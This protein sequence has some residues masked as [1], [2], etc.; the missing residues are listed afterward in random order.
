MDTFTDVQFMTAKE[1]TQVLKAWTRFLKSGLKPEAFTKALYHHLTLHC[2][3]IAHYDRGGFYSVYFTSGDATVRF[4]RQFDLSGRRSSVE[5]GGDGWLTR[6]EY[7]DINQALCDA[8]EP[9]KADLY[10]SAMS[11]QQS[12]DLA[13]A[14]ALLAKHGYT[15]VERKE[16]AA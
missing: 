7:R 13:A 6:E 10:Q 12:A 5:Y 2:S 1:K 4:L 9:Y 8:L 14:A 16:Q 11:G 3:F 15:A